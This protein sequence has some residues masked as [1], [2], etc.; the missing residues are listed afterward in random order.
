MGT[1]WCA[2]AGQTHDLWRATARFAK[3]SE[4]AGADDLSLAPTLEDDGDDETGIR[5]EARQGIPEVLAYVVRLALQL[6]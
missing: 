5:H 3:L 6:P 2:S 4:P 1:R